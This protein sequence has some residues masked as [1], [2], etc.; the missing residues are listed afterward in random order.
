MVPLPDPKSGALRLGALSTV[1]VTTTLI[2]TVVVSVTPSAV[3]YVTTVTATAA[4]SSPAENLTPVRMSQDLVP[5]P[6]PPVDI[7]Y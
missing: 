3:I 2:S 4:H 6:A 7:L 5:A 1:A